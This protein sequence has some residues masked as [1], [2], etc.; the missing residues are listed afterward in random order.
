MTVLAVV[1]LATSIYAASLVPFLLLVN[2]EHLTPAWLR[3]IPA[4]L[5]ALP[6]TVAALLLIL[7]GKHHA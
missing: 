1:C 4:H 3:R 6:L 2:A 7:G 5:H